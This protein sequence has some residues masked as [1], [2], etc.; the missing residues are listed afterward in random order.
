MIVMIF[1]T[2]NNFLN[3][4]GICDRLLGFYHNPQQKVSFFHIFLSFFQVGVSAVTD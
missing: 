2:Q 1:L 4:P 3:G